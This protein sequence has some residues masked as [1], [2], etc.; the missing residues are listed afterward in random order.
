M[1]YSY[2]FASPDR[3]RS[4]CELF[5]AIEFKESRHSSLWMSIAVHCVLLSALLLIPLIFTDA[6]KLRYDTVLIVPPPP[7]LKPIL[8]V[9]HYKQLMPKPEPKMEK[10]LVAPPPVKPLLV[11]PPLPK[12]PEP[13]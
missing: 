3:D 8:E 9:T 13:P 12:P 4:H 10:P 11:Q 1:A 7:P 2:D 5:R 6:I